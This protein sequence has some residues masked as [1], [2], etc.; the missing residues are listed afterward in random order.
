MRLS[1]TRLAAIAHA[2]GFGDRL[3]DLA[4]MPSMSLQFARTR[5]LIDV[6]S[7]QSL[8]TFSRLSGATTI[9]SA[10]QVQVVAAGVPRITHDPVTLECLGLLLEEQR[11]NAVTNNTMVGAVAGT[12]GTPPTGW[13]I[14]VS[15][16]GLTRAIVGSGI[17]N[18]INYIDV[19]FNG[20]PSSTSEITVYLSPAVATATLGQSWAASTW[21]SLV[22][23]STSNIAIISLRNFELNSGAYVRE[24]ATNFVSSIS[25]AFVRR[26][27]ITTSFGASANQIQSALSINAA[28]GGTPIDITL[29]IGLPQLELGSE[30]TSV[31]P[32]AGTSVVRADD[33]AVM[34]GVN[35]SSWY[36]QDEGTVFAEAALAQPN[37]GGN[38]FV[39]RPSDN[40]FNNQI[41]LN[42][43]GGGFS[44]M[45][46]AT[47]G[48]FDGTATSAGLLSANTAAKL[49]GAYAANN[50]GLSLN[51][52]TVAV[53]TSATM[54]T[55]LTRAD[56]GSDHI[57]F[58]RV[59]A[60]TIRRLDFWPRRLPNSILQ[61]LTR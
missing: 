15:P 59:K 57:G 56:I 9:N 18:G 40:S 12:P 34:T 32:T 36:R 14:F 16:T 38:Q 54:P 53:D 37:S 45:A 1:A 19:R 24:T 48:V 17:V 4:G 41:A 10:G 52:E 61:E 21:L 22:G 47:G 35:F 5:S 44:S 60:G 51:G 20:T 58:N 30:A 31:I 8:I 11:A 2:R 23:G 39:F 28:A 6:V 50:L 3:W 49:A 13:S 43:Q 26:Q 42:I 33:V 29:R 46:T 27:N 7:G 55:A 25:S